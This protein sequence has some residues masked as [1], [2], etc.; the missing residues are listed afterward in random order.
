MMN[1]PTFWSN[2]PL[3]LLSACEAHWLF[4]P[5]SL[6]E[7][8]TT[9]GDYALER[10]DQHEASAGP[11]DA[12]LLGVPSGTPVWVRTVLMRLDDRPCVTARSVA[13]VDALDH[14]WPSLAGYG[15]LPL[16]KILYDDPAIAR[17][18][19]E[20]ALL[21]PDEPL[22][23]ISRRYASTPT[24]LRARRSTFIRNGSPLVVSECFLPEFWHGFADAALARA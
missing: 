12:M 22:D 5:G 9:L 6:T 10:L 8:L 7:R 3:P 18:P 16:G 21:A 14:A 24:P 17:T 13:P 2:R 19:F 4:A 20:C 15:G 11:A 1:A 23:A